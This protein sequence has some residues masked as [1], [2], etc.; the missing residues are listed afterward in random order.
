MA[1]SSINVLNMTPP[2][3]IS[4]VQGMYP[5]IHPKFASS[6]LAVMMRL[7]NDSQKTLP[8]ALI[9]ELSANN[10]EIVLIQYATALAYRCSRF[11]EIPK[12]LKFLLDEMICEHDAISASIDAPDM[13]SKL[14]LIKEVEANQS[15][16]FTEI[17]KRVRKNEEQPIT[18]FSVSNLEC[19]RTLPAEL[20]NR[21]DCT[22][23]C[24]SAFYYAV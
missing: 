3:F 17:I 16:L 19:S 13:H 6:I 5:Q 18:G 4:R 22:F 14:E 9:T 8:G 1:D 20:V 21:L 23:Q 12:Q 2:F 15:D 24:N 7:L 10:K 11:K